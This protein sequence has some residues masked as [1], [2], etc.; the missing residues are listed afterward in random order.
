MTHEQDE[1]ALAIGR[2]VL[3]AFNEWSKKPAARFLKVPLQMPFGSRDL[4]SPLWKM[5]ITAEMPWF[6]TR[7][8]NGSLQQVTM[9]EYFG[10]EKPE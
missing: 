6:F 7:D 8:E 10:W 4:L 1:V 9:F 3:K 2:S 5:N